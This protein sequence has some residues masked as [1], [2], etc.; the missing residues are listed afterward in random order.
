MRLLRKPVPSSVAAD[1]HRPVATFKNSLRA[2]QARYKAQRGIPAQTPA[3]AASQAV[4][5]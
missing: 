5:V 2:W 1:S 3:K 4:V